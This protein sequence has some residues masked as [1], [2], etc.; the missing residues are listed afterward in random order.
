MLEKEIY[1]QF[2]DDYKIREYYPG[3]RTIV[4]D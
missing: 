3:I 2:A 1:L 4:N